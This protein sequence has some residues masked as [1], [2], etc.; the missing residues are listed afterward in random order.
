M[1]KIAV[2]VVVFIL[3][4]ISCYAMPE[5]TSEFFVND[6]ANV[7]DDETEKEILAIGAQL[8]KDT[9]AQLVAVTVD[10]TDGQ[11]VN[12]YALK[13]GREWGVGQKKEN[14]GVILLVAVEDRKISI[15][16]GYGLEGRLNDSKTG[17]ILDNYAVPYLKDNDFS[18]GIDKTYRALAS[19]IYAEYGVEMPENFDLPEA[20]PEEDDG[21][22][23]I[24]IIVFAFIMI[25]LLS[26]GRF[27]PIGFGGGFRG[28]GYRG[29]FGGGSRGSGG[30]FGGFSGGGG[31]FGGGGSSRGF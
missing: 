9:A 3:L 5:A 11:D 18:T 17:R 25:L 26:G 4:S 27:L 20:L 12:E 7:L 10:T 22:L 1:K 15:Q 19:E 28:G 29:G 13:L 2:F 21:A 16:V 6:F 14:N 24:G 31:S 23:V 30:G 8:Q